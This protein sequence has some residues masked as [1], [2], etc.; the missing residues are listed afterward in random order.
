MAI[1]PFAAPVME[2]DHGSEIARLLID[3]IDHGMINEGRPHEDCDFC[4]NLECGK[5]W[6]IYEA[7]AYDGSPLP[8][9][10][11]CISCDLTWP[12]EMSAR[13]DS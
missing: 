9:V 3:R 8:G 11:V 13:W 1:M 10:L 2:A 7:T 6:T 5:S 4:P 12:A